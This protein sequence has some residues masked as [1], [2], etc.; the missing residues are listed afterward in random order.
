MYIKSHLIHKT[1][2]VGATNNATYYDQLTSYQ[3][4]SSISG[5]NIVHRLNY[6]NGIPYFLFGFRARTSKNNSIK[7][8]YNPNVVKY[9][10]THTKN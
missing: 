6:D 10:C 5:I 2:G 4:P 8:M 3:E 1:T 7:N 9:S